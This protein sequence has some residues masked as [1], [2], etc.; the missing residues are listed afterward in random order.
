MDA[1]GC[2]L[3]ALPTLS[4]LPPAPVAAQDRKGS[5]LGVTDQLAL[6]YI[7]EEG[8]GLMEAAPEEPRV[9]LL[10]NATLRVRP[11]PVLRFPSGHVAFVQRAPWRAGVEPYVVHATFQRFPTSLHGLGK[12]GRFRC[13]QRAGNATPPPRHAGP[14]LPHTHIRHPN[15]LCCRETGLWLLDGPD[16]YGA[17][18]G[19]TRFL[20]YDNDVRREVER[21]AA[22]RFPG[23]AMPV[24]Y[25]HMVAVAYQLALFRD[26]LA[27]ARMLGRA[28]VLPRSWCWCDYDWTPDVLESCKIRCGGLPAQLPL[29][30]GARLEGGAGRWRA[31]GSQ[32]TSL[33][34]CPPAAA[35]TRSCRLSAP[36]I[37][38]F[39]CRTWISR[40]STTACPPF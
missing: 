1:A 10:R 30:L 38:S 15:Q 34:P 25:R 6:H 9:L 19:T 28:L 32:P 12:R 2:H 5:I 22:A 8:V 18:P 13:R 24:L 4:P 36:L 3:T 17:A 29:R 21:A 33:L 14:S 7:L 27:A 11:L 39:I 35:P 37:L 40:A 16:Y 20:T 26:A 23:G 31:S